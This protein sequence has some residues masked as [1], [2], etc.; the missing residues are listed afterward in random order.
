MAEVDE[1]LKRIETENVRWLDLQFVDLAGAL[2]HTTIA[3]HELTEDSVL[4]GLGRLDG[5]SIRGF[6]GI[7]ESDLV[8][9]PDL[10]TYHPIPWE[11]RAG[12]CYANIGEAFGGDRYTKDS[13]FIAER[14]E[15]AVKSAGYTNAFLGPE[16]EFYIFD[17]VAYNT[18]MPYRGQSYQ[19]ESREGAWNSFGQNFPIGFKRGYY[20]APPQDLMQLVRMQIAEVLEDSFG[21]EVEC[22]HHEVGSAGQGEI[23]FK[24]DSLGGAADK[25]VLLKYVIK[26]IAAANNQIATFMP[27]PV[28]GDNGSGM[29]TH[30]SIWKNNSNTFYDAGDKYAELS[31]TARYFIGGLLEHGKALCAFT[32]PTTNSYKRLVQGF[33]APVYLCW[34]RRNRSAAV[35]V[36]VYDKGNEASKRIEFRVPDPSANPYFAFAAIMAAGLDGIRKKADPG[37]PVDEDVYSMDEKARKSHGIEAVCG[38]LGE[39]LDALKSDD[40]FLKGIFTNEVLDSYALLKRGEEKENG[41]M[42][43]PWEFQEYLNV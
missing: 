30:V 4:A 1:F 26:N 25:V 38:S 42:P 11:M 7:A 35:R 3:T 31:Q 21:F 2:Q 23:T 24:Y 15:I 36:P 34:S 37:D 32:N 9:L 14:A 12:L 41:R 33:E 13:R 29:H 16:V 19:I 17:S 39:S 40:K 27:K 22:H 43:T 20:P 28:Y 8:L 5:S 18:S 6:Q 10:S